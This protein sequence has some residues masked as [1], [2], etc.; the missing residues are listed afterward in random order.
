MS[1]R[2]IGGPGGALGGHVTP[3]VGISVHFAAALPPRTWQGEEGVGSGIRVCID[4]WNN[5]GGEAPAIDLKFGDEILASKKVPKADLLTGLDFADMTVRLQNDGTVDVMFKDEIVFWDVATPSAS[6][7]KSRFGF[8]ART[9]GAN[10]VHGI[11]D[12]RLAMITEP[13]PIIIVDPP[14]PIS[15]SRDDSGNLIIEWT[16]ILQTAENVNGPWVDVN[17]ASP[18]I[19]RPEDLAKQQYARSRLP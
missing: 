8:G 18:L 16:G 12:L 5:G 7:K 19:L 6:Y 14:D 17:T 10:A 3:G 13:P 11:D 1:G 4:T 15:I 2:G 9:G